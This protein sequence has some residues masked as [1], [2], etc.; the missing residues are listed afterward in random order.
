L[1]FFDRILEG[2]SVNAVL[3]NDREGAYQATRHL[4]EQGC[5]R[6]AHFAGPQHLNIY[7]NRRQGY[8]DALQSYG[9]ASEEDLITDCDMTLESGSACMAQLLALPVPPDAVFSA[10]DTANLGALQLLKS[11]GIRVPQDVALAG[12]SN[13]ALT[14]VT[15]PMLTSVDQRTEEMGQAAFRL[16]TELLEAEGT[17]FSQR[18]VVL[19]P[20]LFVRAS[21]LRNG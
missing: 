8:L 7:K 10:G 21:S 4:L 12:F 2:D 11:R 16:F 5:R 19:Q 20:Q 17:S 15:E 3:L 13:E 14:L 18:Q 6:V 9:I 1:V